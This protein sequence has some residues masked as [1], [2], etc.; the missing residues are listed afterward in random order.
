MTFMSDYE[1]LDTVLEAG[2]SGYPWI[3]HRWRHIQLH[4]AFDELMADYWQQ[5]PNCG[6]SHGTI[7]ELM[8]WSYV[9]TLNPV[10]LNPH[11]HHMKKF[12]LLTSDGENIDAMLNAGLGVVGLQFAQ[13]IA[14]GDGYIAVF[15]RTLSEI[16]LSDEEIA[17]GLKRW[18]LMPYTIPP[19]TPYGGDAG[20]SASGEES[21]SSPAE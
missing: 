15:L 20:S 5:N 21:S 16:T 18:L 19:H 2:A 11:R 9:Q 12:W 8:E 1:G 6:F 14:G 3:Q 7:G 13:L 10:N 17:A 4:R